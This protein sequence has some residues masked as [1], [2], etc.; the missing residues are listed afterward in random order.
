MVIYSIE[1]VDAILGSIGPIQGRPTFITLWQLSQLIFESLWKL[2]HPKYPN[3]GWSGYKMPPAM[4]TLFPTHLWQDPIN[5]GTYFVI[6]HTAITKTDQESEEKNWN[7]RRTCATPLIIF[8]WHSRQCWSA[9]HT[10]GTAGLAC[11]GFCNN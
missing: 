11:Q 4:F 3:E 1:A 7:P 10:G 2:T 5:L 9:F 6:P 8:D